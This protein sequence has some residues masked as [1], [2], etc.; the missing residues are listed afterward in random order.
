MTR[1]IFASLIALSTTFSSQAADSSKYTISGISSGGFMANQM[2]TIYSSQFS[3]VGSVAGGFYYCAENYLQSRIKA[4]AFT[5]GANDLFLYEPTK[6]IITDSLN[7]F[8]LGDALTPG[9]WFTPSRRNPLYQSVTICMR[10]ADS[11]QLPIDYLISNAEKKLIEPLENLASQKAFIYQGKT[12]SVMDQS[13]AGMLKSFYLS[14]G[15]KEQN[16]AT[17]L[18][19]GNHNF[20]TDFSDNASC[21]NSGVPYVSSCGLNLAEKMLH[22]LISPN[23]V[24]ASAHLEN[25][26]VIDQSLDFANLSVQEESWT[27]PV[28]SIAPYG[29]LY[30]NQ[31]CLNS[32]GSCK[33]H[34]AMHGCSMSDSYSDEFQAKYRN[35]VVKYKIVKMTSGKK[36]AFN[37]PVIHNPII[38]TTTIEENIPQYGLLKFVMDSGYINYAD[39]NDLMI[40]FPQTW[41]SEINFP[42]NPA[43]CWDWYGWTG[44][45][46]ATNQ[47]VEANW[48]MSFIKSVA[49]QPKNHLM[50]VRPKF[51]MV[52]KNFPRGK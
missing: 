50:N 17:V 47:G 44:E 28:P 26:H 21:D 42:Y 19:E 9:K 52:E 15:I 48:L 1:F 24:R 36:N 7:P 3:G 39:E 46:Y 25:I 8:R 41:I 43:G 4:D 29:Y 16:I 23:L 37:I 38:K 2:A 40:L 32:P 14:V 18:G 27:T 22:H 49:T 51:E 30:A 6:K 10:G 35:Q 11:A 45:N 33:L 12:D 13:M 20:P 5:I 31:K 34:V